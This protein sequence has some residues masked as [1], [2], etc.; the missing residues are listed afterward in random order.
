M[1]EKYENFMHTFKE[2]GDGWINITINWSNF[3]PPRLR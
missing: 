2:G 3:M 1:S